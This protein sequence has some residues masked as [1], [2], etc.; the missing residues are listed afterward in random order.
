MSDECPF[1]GKPTNTFTFLKPTQIIYLSVR[2]KM[3]CYL[4]IAIIYNLCA[5]THIYIDC[6]THM[7]TDCQN[8]VAKGGIER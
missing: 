7:Y 2:L 4:I 8:S 1:L 3:L 5:H 6:L